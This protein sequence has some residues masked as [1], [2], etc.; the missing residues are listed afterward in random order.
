MQL[1][2][3][4]THLEAAT[5]QGRVPTPFQ[6]LHPP[7]PR[8]G[9]AQPSS[10]PAARYG[11][12]LCSAGAKPGCFAVT[13]LCLSPSNARELLEAPLWTCSPSKRDFR[14][15]E[16]PAGMLSPLVTVTLGAS[17]SLQSPGVGTLC[18]FSC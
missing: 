10:L 14:L 18:L 11:R 3:S 17:R 4:N 15:K 1:S 5:A 7:H 2:T 6:R 16:Q 8:Q 9:T 13:A 12:G